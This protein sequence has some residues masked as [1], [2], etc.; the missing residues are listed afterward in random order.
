MEYP[1]FA[2]KLESYHG[3]IHLGM[4][5]P[6]VFCI[7]DTNERELEKPDD[8]RKD[9]FSRQAG[10]TQILL[11][12]STY[13]RQGTPKVNEAFIFVAVSHLAPTR[14]IAILCSAF[15]IPSFRLQMSFRVGTNPHISPC[16]RND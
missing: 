9:L 7:A 2:T 13:Q 12:Y 10:S 16:R 3:S 1:A 14:M 15:G 4:P 8:R 5:I 11:D 6:H